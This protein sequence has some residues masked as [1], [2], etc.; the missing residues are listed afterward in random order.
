MIWSNEG[1]PWNAPVPS[2]PEYL[3]RLRLHSGECRSGCRSNPA[4][5]DSDAA[6]QRLAILLSGNEQ[7]DA[8]K[9]NVNNYYAKGA[10]QPLDDALASTDSLFELWLET[11]GGGCRNKRH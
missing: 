8:F 10:I 2:D 4:A 5:E 9:G 1:G 11:Y 7:M 3:E 6:T